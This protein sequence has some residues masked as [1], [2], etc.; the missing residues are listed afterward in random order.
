[1]DVCPFTETHRFRQASR[2]SWNNKQVGENTHAM[3]LP[4]KRK[5][6][7]SIVSKAICKSDSNPIIELHNMIG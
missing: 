3:S 7:L 5:K 6:E 1:M 2:P 4:T